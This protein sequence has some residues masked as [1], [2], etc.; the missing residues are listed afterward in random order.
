MRRIEKK[1]EP[2][3][4]RDN[5][6]EWTAEYIADPNNKTKKY[7]YRNDQI[8]QTLK[9]ET[10]NKCVYCESKIGH[11]T[12]GDVEHKVPSSVNRTKHFEWDNLTIAC[13]E[14]NRR[15]NAYFSAQK[16]FLD[17]YTDQVEELVIH[18][19]PIVCWKPG[20]ENAEITIKTLELHS[21]TRS[22]LIARK[23]EKIE[24]LNNLVERIS[25]ATGVMKEMLEIQ[26][27]GMRS[28]DAEYS[29]MICTIC[30]TIE[31]RGSERTT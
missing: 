20:A 16:P 17:P 8:K 7:R 24:A 11:N 27:D 13:T 26:L 15:K 31:L 1:G 9:D 3:I 21:T 10:S 18:Y 29:G 19:G 25:R 4:L 28:R 6:I 23:V 5:K 30:E 2:E 12:P 22:E 14:C